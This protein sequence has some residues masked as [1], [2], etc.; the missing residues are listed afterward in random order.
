MD[1]IPILVPPV[2]NM[3]RAIAVFAL[4]GVGVVAWPG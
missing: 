3:V 1:G 4:I 2:L